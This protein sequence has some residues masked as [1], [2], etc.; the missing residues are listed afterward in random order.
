[1]KKYVKT[2]NTILTRNIDVSHNGSRPSSTIT[3]AHR[4]GTA[5][6]KDY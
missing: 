4:L 6:L 1:M 5:V 2:N 3:E